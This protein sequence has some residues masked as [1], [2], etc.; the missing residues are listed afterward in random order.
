MGLSIRSGATIK[1]KDM[2]KAL[3]QPPFSDRGNEEWPMLP[4][5]KHRFDPASKP[6]GSHNASFPKNT[7]F[8]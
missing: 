1:D 6:N 2:I 5:F 7:F 8:V 4:P 3:L